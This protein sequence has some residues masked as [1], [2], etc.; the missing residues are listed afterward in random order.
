MS[1]KQVTDEYTGETYNN[2]SGDEIAPKYNCIGDDT[3]NITEF[4]ENQGLLDNS[5]S[6]I[7]GSEVT[8]K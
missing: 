4:G 8:T 5:G 3:Y 2:C 6:V 7:F 1:C